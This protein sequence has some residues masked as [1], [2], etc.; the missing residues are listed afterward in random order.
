[1]CCKKNFILYTNIEKLIHSINWLT[2]KDDI[3]Y[4]TQIVQF[5]TSEEPNKFE[6]IN[7][8]TKK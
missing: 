5:V 1:M 3:I 4:I 2:L 7:T 8:T 6:W